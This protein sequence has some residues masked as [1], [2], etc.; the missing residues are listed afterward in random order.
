M[1]AVRARAGD[2]G[3]PSAPALVCLVALAAL[4]PWALGGAPLPAL[5]AVTAAALGVAALALVRGALGRGASL[6]AVPLWPL[7]AFAA[8]AL[9]QLVP[10]P[11]A[12][13]AALAPGSYA[14]WHPADP[15]AAAVLGGGARP[16]SLDP[17]ATLRAAALVA[18]LGLLAAL[19][20]PLLA[21]ERAATLAGFALAAAGFA[22]AAYAIVARARFGALLYGFVRVPT[23]LPF[24]PFVNKNHFAGWAAMAFPIAGGL[25]AG[26]AAAARARSEDWTAG[27]RA[28]PV[29]LAVVAAAAMALAVLV[30]LSRGGVLALLGGALALAVFVARPRLGRRRARGLVPSLILAGALGA[31]VLAAAPD[32]AHERL[33]TLSGASFR[34]ETWRDALRLARSSPLVGSGLGAF[35][36]AYPRFKT[37]SGELRVEH[38]ESEYVE[39]LA[40]TG[41]AGL[42]AALGGLLLLFRA[43]ARSAAPRGVAWGVG[44]GGLAALVALAVH[45]LLDFDLRLPSN[46]ALAA[47]AAAAAA[48]LAG[49]RARPLSRPAC[50]ALAAGALVLLAVSWPAPAAPHLVAREELR[51]AAE[52]PS[53][54]V[55]ALRLARAE[56]ALGAALSRRPAR[57][58]SWLLL[59][60]ARAARGDRASVA[61]LARHAVSLD[62]RR[63]GL[64]EASLGLAAVAAR[65]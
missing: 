22:L 16:I 48:G 50:A 20:A 46:A 3:R 34:L 56:A 19:A 58:E 42:A 2:P 43:A 29:V 45:G 64:R 8:L 51:L 33:R 25:A 17:G 65:P 15:A 41:L 55:R 59:A 30:S 4:A 28:G 12:L 44:G 6:P 47:L 62:P 36:D 5:R 18:G 54:E 60:H 11:A 24:G 31:L 1:R 35:H 39:A 10:L 23:V 9:A 27:R 38:A 40:E 63:P 26:L 7:A 57:A 49:S 21:R 61:A 14:V 53:A 37:G 13:H 52:A 32:S